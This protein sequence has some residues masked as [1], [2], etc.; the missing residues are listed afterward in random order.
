LRLPRRRRD[1]EEEAAAASA[2]DGGEIGKRPAD[3]NA[4]A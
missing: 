2:I 3:V 1:L 4:D